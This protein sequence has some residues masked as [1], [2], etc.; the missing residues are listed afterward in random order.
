MRALAVVRASSMN[1]SDVSRPTTR[2]NPSVSAIRWVVNPGPHPRSIAIF[3]ARFCARPSLV[4]GASRKNARVECS[5]TCARS[6]SRR[7]AISVSPKAYMGFIVD[8]LKGSISPRFQSHS[9]MISN[10]DE[11]S[12]KRRP[13]TVRRAKPIR[14]ALFVPGNREDRM[15]K[16]PRFG[17]DALILD[18]EDAV[19][20]PDKE[21]ARPV[22]RNVL[23]Q[24][25]KAGH[26]LMV[27]VNDFETALTWADLDAIVCPFIYAIM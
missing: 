19:A 14:S 21:K 23:E 20:L 4:A 7:A 18:L 26:T 12:T 11:K 1:R 2:L 24:L 8:S 17:A 25:G 15:L 3:C 5:K 27:R 13:G 10:S 16:A 9:E 6:S 22:V